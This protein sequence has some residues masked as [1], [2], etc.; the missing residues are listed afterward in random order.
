[1]LIQPKEIEVLTGAGDEGTR[2]YVISKLPATVARE[3]I[4]QYPVSAIPKLGDYAR[5]EEL[6]L[7]LMGYV[8]LPGAGALKTRALIDNHVPDFET[9][10]RLEMAMLEYN[11]SFFAKGKASGFLASLAEKVQALITSTL[12]DSLRVLSKK[13]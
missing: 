1:M 6:M 7:K 9:L 3:V 4:T 2:T 12:T 13:D 11:C 10:A 8:E 5:N